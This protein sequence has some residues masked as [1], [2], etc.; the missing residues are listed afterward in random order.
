MA[1]RADGTIADHQ[2]MGRLRVGA[3]LGLVVAAAVL[4]WAAMSS[5]GS[6]AQAWVARAPVPESGVVDVAQ[7]QLADVTLPEPAVLWPATTV[8]SGV[9]TRSIAPGQPLLGADLTSA[10][11][12]G[13]RRVTLPV[14]P[15]QMP[16]GLVA[17]DVV[18]VWTAATTT[19]P[20][21][22]GVVVQQVSPPDIGTG[23]V[24][25]AVPADDVPAAVRA[26]AA[27]QVVLARHP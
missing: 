11:P 24:E 26:T 23:R 18:D 8:P 27:E 14:D 25:I 10:A 13:L 4:A 9:T 2:R 7:F 3:G 19:G 6:T 12:A 15:D 5:G 20:L 17:G 21:I 22:A 16:E 1:A